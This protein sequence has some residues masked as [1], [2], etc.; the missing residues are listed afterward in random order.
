IRQSI[1]SGNTGSTCPA[2]YL[3]DGTFISESYNLFGANPG[4]LP[5]A[6]SDKVAPGGLAPFNASSAIV[7]LTR[8]SPSRGAIPTDECATRSDQLGVSR[9]QGSGYDSGAVEMR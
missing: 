8:D 3:Y 9:P 4:Q 6:P 1:V 5:L 2:V 7:P